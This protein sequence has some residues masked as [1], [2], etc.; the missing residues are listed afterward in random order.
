MNEKAKFV[1]RDEQSFALVS[2][3]RPSIAAIPLLAIVQR[4]TV[5]DGVGAVR[6]DDAEVPG[7]PEDGVLGGPAH[8]RWQDLPPSLL[9]LPPLQG[10]PQ[11]TCLPCFQ[12]AVNGNS[13]HRPC[14]RCT[15]GS[16][17]ISPS[18]FVT[19]EGRLYCKHH[20]AQLFMTK[21]NFSSFTKVEEDKHE[22]IILQVPS[23]HVMIEGVQ[24]S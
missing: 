1:P 5:G 4:L 24:V 9:P 21:G 15:H 17:T 16:C 11:V 3:I 8:R 2:V 10:N 19:H 20:H 14:F 13:Y 18:N 23:D 6:R 7:V 22:D 12:V